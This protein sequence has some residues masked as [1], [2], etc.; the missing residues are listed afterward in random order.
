[1][2]DDEIESKGG[3]EEGAFRPEIVQR[4]SLCVAVPL[5]QQTDSPRS[6]AR[7]QRTESSQKHLP[8]WHVECQRAVDRRG[9]QQGQLGG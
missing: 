4:A 8:G 5:L 6:N 3:Q 1:M 2:S 9:V 7:P